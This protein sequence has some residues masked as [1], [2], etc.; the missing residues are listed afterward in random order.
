MRK[1]S[2][3]YA[4]VDRPGNRA[5]TAQCGRVSALAAPRHHH[6]RLDRGAK[7]RLHPLRHPA[8]AGPPPPPRGGVP[9]SPPATNAGA[10]KGPGSPASKGPETKIVLVGLQERL[11]AEATA[12]LVILSCAV[13]FVLLIACVNVGGLL[14]AQGVSREREIR[15][16]LA[17]GA[18]RGRVVRQ[19]LTESLL[20]TSLG[21]L[22]GIWIAAT[23]VRWLRASG[24]AL[25]RPDLGASS[26]VPRLEEVSLDGTVLLFALAISLVAALACG[27]APALRQSR[28]DLTGDPYRRTA[29]SAPG[30][31]VLGRSRARACLLIVQVGLAIILLLG[32][33]LLIRSFV[34]LTNVNPGYD[35]SHVLTFQV[36]LPPGRSPLAFSNDL[37]ARLRTFPGVLA[38]GYADHLPLTRSSLSGLPTFILLST[39]PLAA[40]IAP[41][42]PPPGAVGKPGF[43]AV[44]VVS[45]DFLSAMG[46]A[47]VEGHGFSDITP[48][49]APPGLLI[50]RTL[51][52]SGFLGEHPIGARVYT[53]GTTPWTV[54]GVVEDAR[55]SA[56]A[57]PPGH[58]IFVS[59]E[60]SGATDAVFGS[61]SAYFAVRVAEPAGQMMPLVRDA[62]RDLDPNA[63]PD[64]VAT[65]EELLSNSVLRPRFY[66]EIFALFAAVA[67]ALAV[68]GIYGGIAFA[69]SGRTREIAIRRALGASAAPPLGRHGRSKPDAG[70]HRHR[71]RTGRRSAVD[72]ISGN[73]ALRF[74][75][76]RS[77][78]LRRSAADLRHG[79]GRGRASL[80]AASGNRDSL[81]GPQTRV[82]SQG[83][84]SGPRCAAAKS[85]HQR[86]SRTLCRAPSVHRCVA[87][88]RYL[89]W[90]G[91]LLLPRTERLNRI[92][93]R[94]AACG[95]ERRHRRHD[96]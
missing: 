37:T 47:V 38:A 63:V 60:Q 21:G 9:P 92:D 50:N 65:M 27:L 84:L 3:C 61:S 18:G 13:G 24:T 2:V 71:R 75:A 48:A 36:A 52:R 66:A 68:V 96:E 94:G 25:P 1:L 29:S 33:G 79:R 14:L 19:L 30:L 12:P 43:P 28:A 16:R 31:S 39:E 5:R 26:I 73:D 55:Q 23:G 40:A 49:D 22:A 34:K 42:P 58:Q 10:R 32:G 6:Q 86:R 72:A 62:V 57:D 77:R 45:R 20:L 51:A 53:N 80:G 69:V 4:R 90:V 81:R 59:M 11:V 56:L 89:S 54:M 93:C 41:P 15:V 87:I 7:D 88:D 85:N 82:A 17:L 8:T 83:R 74:S 70:R 64:R 78:S 46:M 91:A 35:T 67:G 44:Q 95:Q 76:A